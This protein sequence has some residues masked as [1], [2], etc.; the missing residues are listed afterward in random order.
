MQTYKI[1]FN[2]GFW[3]KLVYLLQSK[4]SL[5]LCMKFCDFKNFN[6][7]LK[8]FVKQEEKLDNKALLDAWTVRTQ[9]KS[10]MLK[11]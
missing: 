5:H 6:F 7:I 9:V 3:K 1:I 4:M 8:A 11:K 10:F 2:L